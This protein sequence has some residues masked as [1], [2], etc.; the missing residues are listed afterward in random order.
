MLL[1]FCSA[2]GAPAKVSAPPYAWILPKSG[3]VSDPTSEQTVEAELNLAAQ[4]LGSQ[5]LG[6]GPQEDCVLTELRYPWSPTCALNG[7]QPFTCGPCLPPLPAL[8]CLF[9]QE[10]LPWS[11]PKWN[12]RSVW[13]AANL[14]RTP[15]SN[16]QT[17]TFHRC[18][19][20]LLP[21]CSSVRPG[22][23]QPVLME[24]SLP[25][26]IWLWNRTANPASSPGEVPE[27]P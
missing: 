15:T 14:P 25:Y 7:S 6:L 17:P 11:V 23:R 13:T 16:P 4:S 2:S 24:L 27:A 21:S 8:D 5:E 19:E 3:S 12:L 10:L 1:A 26:P 18:L 9:L 20:L 22:D